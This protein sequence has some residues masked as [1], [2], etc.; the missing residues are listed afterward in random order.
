MVRS[1]SIVMARLSLSLIFIL[2]SVQ[3]MFTWHAT[4]T[5]LFEVLSD[6]VTRLSYSEWATRTFA[7]LIPWTPII[8]MAAIL[9]EFVGGILV[10]LGV[11]EKL[12]AGLLIAFLVPTT[13]IMHPFWY[14]DGLQSE[15][16]SIMFL[17]NFAMIGGLL[18]VAV[19]GAQAK[20]GATLGGFA[21]E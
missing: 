14:H 3:K 5:Q 8:L 9:L 4:E 12:G 2:S 11:R 18:M 1:A 7:A 17:K 20:Q 16:Q 6:W 15:L 13:L 10:L 21:L 19:H